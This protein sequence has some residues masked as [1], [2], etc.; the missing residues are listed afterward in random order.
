MGKSKFQIF[1]F[2][3]ITIF[4][5]LILIPM[6][7][8]FFFLWDSGSAKGKTEDWFTLYGSI[9]GGLIGGFFTYLALIYTLNYD[10]S[11]LKKEELLMVKESVLMIREYI[12]DLEDNVIQLGAFIPEN[13]QKEMNHRYEQCLSHDV[14]MDDIF[15]GQ[16]VKIS[17]LDQ[18]LKRLKYTQKIIKEFKDEMRDRYIQLKDIEDEEF[19]NFVYDSYLALSHYEKYLESCIE[20]GDFNLKELVYQ[21]NPEDMDV[22]LRGIVHVIRDE[23]SLKYY[24]KYIRTDN[25]EAGDILNKVKNIHV[26]G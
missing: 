1:K 6:I 9:F 18:Y 13:I 24:Q 21:F 16:R 5:S 22:G 14:Y 11:K 23:I 15:Q 20:N 2:L 8:N 17:Q 10:K 12:N 7:F 25:D 19:L 4:V 26:R 3:A